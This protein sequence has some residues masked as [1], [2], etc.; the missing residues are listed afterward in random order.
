MAI[1]STRRSPSNDQ[2][3]G[4]VL[5][6]T[7]TP[8]QVTVLRDALLAAQ[9]NHATVAKRFERGDVPSPKH[10]NR[11]RLLDQTSEPTANNTMI[12]WFTFGLNVPQPLAEATVGPAF[13]ELAVDL[14]LLATEGEVCTPRSS[15]LPTENCWIASD[16]HQRLDSDAEFDHVLSINPAARFLRDFMLREPVERAL[17]LCCGCGYHALEASLHAGEVIATDLNARATAF[18][19]FNAA[20]NGRTNISCRTGDLLEPVRGERFDQIVCNPPFVLAPD[21]RF[22]SLSNELELDEF[23]ANVVRQVPEQLSDGG[24]FQMICEWVEIE[25][26]PW[27]ERLTSWFTGSACD[28]WVLH[29]YAKPPDSYAQMRLSESPLASESE[30]QGT[31]DAWIEHFRSHRVTAIHGGLIVVRRRGKGTAG[32]PWLRFEEFPDRPSGSFGDWVRGGLNRHTLLQ[33]TV[34]DDA[35]LRAC[36]LK[37]A[38]GVI[39]EQTAT[40]QSQGWRM[41]QPKL[42][43]GHAGKPEIST[44]PDVAQ[45]VAR[46]DGIRTAGALIDELTRRVAARRDVARAESLE[47]VRRFVERGFLL[48]VD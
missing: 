45:F 2:P 38:P 22:V 40:Q 25:D 7:P 17:D 43:F 30:D 44:S 13:I 21:R 8:E 42:Q 4:A 9:Y 14:G 5:L 26:T 15:L 35:K 47:V 36:R 6:S 28:G 1:A 23:C 11:A 48:P 24:A 37:L 19:A 10:R 27:Q 39:L 12:R 46:F 33:A 18:A 16:L 41:E 34:G 29:H 3:W 31:Y 20:I 32:G